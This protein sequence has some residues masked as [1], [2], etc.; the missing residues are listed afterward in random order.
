[1]VL[2]NAS[3]GQRSSGTT[4]DFVL[5]LGAPMV[6]G[7]DRFECGLISYSLENA[8]PNVS[9]TY[10]NNTFSYSPDAGVTWYPVVLPEGT[11]N[12]DQMQS[13]LDAA[14]ISDGFVAGNIVFLPNFATLRVTIVLTAPYQIDLSGSLFYLLL[15][16]SAAQIAA[17][18]TVTTV[19]AN[20]ADINRGVV[21]IYVKVSFV[22]PNSSINSTVQD[23]ILS[24]VNFI[25]QPPGSLVNTRF[26]YPVFVDMLPTRTIDTIRITIVDQDGRAYYL[27]NR[28]VNMQIEIRKK[29][30]ERVAQ[31]ANFGDPRR[32]M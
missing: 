27:R 5:K 18:L 8:N 32:P 1:M 28:P 10:S 9:P 30:V 20:V 13:A 15:G 11:Y 24:D 26:S 29:K 19:G 21:G 3:S 4:D 25:G 6:L 14:V 31:T 23:T 17:P 2:F 12:I 7:G 22:E 16:F